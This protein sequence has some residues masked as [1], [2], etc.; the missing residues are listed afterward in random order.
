MEGLK[1]AFS[2]LSSTW[3]YNKTAVRVLTGLHAYWHP[4]LGFSA[5]I[6][7]RNNFWIN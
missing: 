6:T 1:N 2:S 4:S 7:M 3:G 5:S